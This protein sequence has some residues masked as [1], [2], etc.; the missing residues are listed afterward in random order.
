MTVVDRAYLGRE[1]TLV[2]HTVLNRYL[3]ALA[4]IVG[5]TFAHDIPFVDCCSGPWESVTDDLSDSSIG[6][7][8]QQLSAARDL[9]QAIEFPLP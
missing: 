6:I 3:M 8:I 9:L 5:R 7:A 4:L 2:K 1:Q